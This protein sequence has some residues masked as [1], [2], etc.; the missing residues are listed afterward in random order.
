MNLQPN[1]AALET[2]IGVQF[3]DK[4]LLEHALIHRSFLNEY[5]GPPITS[6]EKM[7]FLGDSV[8]SL[9]TSQYLFTHYPEYNEGIYTDIKAAIVRTESLFEAADTLGVGEFLLLSKG[10][11]DHG[12]RNQKSILA[13]CF[14]ALIAAIFLEAGFDIARQ[15]VEKHLFADRLDTIVQNKDYLPAKNI[16]QEHYQG[17][18]KM[19]PSYVVTA[20]SGPQHSKRYEI[21]VYAQ[22]KI[23][24]TGEGNSKKEA[25][26]N[27][28]RNA[29]EALGI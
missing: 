7:E 28:A 13:D 29:L 5:Q 15:F 17:K 21:T 20:E 16:L 18:Y 9:I 26:E 3:R 8:L 1:L 2:R 11:E 6:N 10:E 23:L 22:N 14:E 19:L 4:Q 25:E 12:G 27:A 24:S